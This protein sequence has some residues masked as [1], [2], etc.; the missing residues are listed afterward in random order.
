VPDGSQT[1]VLE[2]SSTPKISLDSQ[3]C[4]KEQSE[5]SSLDH[6][7]GDIRKLEDSDINLHPANY[8]PS[9]L[10]SQDGERQAFDDQQVKA[11]TGENFNPIREVSEEGESS[12]NSHQKS[13]NR[14]S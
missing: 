11:K 8:L 9:L 10:N 13:L 7:S 1:P 14:N 2:E 5:T 12:N 6:F 4:I 3:Y